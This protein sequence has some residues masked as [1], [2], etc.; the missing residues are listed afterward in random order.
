MAL[1]LG[2]DHSCLL[3]LSMH[4]AGLCPPSGPCAGAAQPRWRQCPLGR[5]CA[6]SWLGAPGQGLTARLSWRLGSQ[7]LRVLPEQGDQQA[8]CTFTCRLPSTPC[9]P[10]GLH[11][12]GAAQQ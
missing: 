1:G 9:S 8:H 11:P 7:D 10:K 6:D 5:S 3:L 12:H 2:G 4:S